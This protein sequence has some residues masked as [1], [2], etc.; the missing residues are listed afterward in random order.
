MFSS[1]AKGFLSDVLPVLYAESFTICKKVY[2]SLSLEV[3]TPFHF[4]LRTKPAPSFLVLADKQTYFE[5]QHHLQNTFYLK[6][7]DLLF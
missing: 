3:N 5:I 2:D 7:H 4:Q 1:T 6:N